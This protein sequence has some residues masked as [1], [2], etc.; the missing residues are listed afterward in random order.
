MKVIPVQSSHQVLINKYVEMLFKQESSKAVQLLESNVNEIASPYLE[1]MIRLASFHPGGSSLYYQR[2]YNIW[3]N[4]NHPPLKPNP[5]NRKIFLLTDFTADH[6]PSL[7]SLFGA[8]YGIDLEIELSPFDSVEQLALSSSSSITKDHI[9]VLIISPQWLQRYLGTSA[10]VSR[11]EFDKTK[12][13]IAS[14]IEG[15]QSQNP[16]QILVANFPG[17]PFPLPGGNLL[18]EEF[19]GQSTAIAEI[20]L[21]LRSIAC[22]NVHLMDFSEAIFGAGG[23]K[24]MAQTNYFRA[25]MVFEPGGVIAASREIALAVATVC[26]KSHRAVVVDWDNTLW[27]GEVAELGYQDVVCGPDSPEGR[28]FQAVQHYI[29]SLTSLGVLLGG[30]SRNS[31]EV[32][33]IFDENSKMGLELDDF[34]STQVSF[35]P[36]SVAIESISEDLGFGEEYMVFLDDSLFELT[37]VF[38]RHPHIDLLMAGPGPDATLHN[39]IESRLF[40]TVS[41]LQDD[42]DRFENSKIL[43]KQR[44]LKTSFK[45]I[46]EFLETIGICLTFCRLNEKN[47]ARAIQLL[48]KSNQFNLTTQRHGKSDL[49]K[50][51]KDGGEINVVS[52]EDAFGS[53]GIISVVILVPNEKEVNIESWVMSC[54]VLNRTVEQAIFSY[55]SES[56]A[57]KTVCGKY[58]PTEKNGLVKNLYSNLGFNF[59]SKDESNGGESWVCPIR[60]K[61]TSLPKHFAKIQEI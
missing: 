35:N 36:K 55:I 24:A 10:L 43:K 41:I 52:Y 58:I 38:T 11:K 26:G 20:N 50:L 49:E 8:S 28:G 19:L 42:L 54:R 22:S 33:S 25:G 3:K 21:W 5:V 40:H 48:Q 32:K 39:L 2:I 56:F 17:G 30:V 34:S 4:L 27:G 15:I 59:V 12:E 44:E 53:Q 18:L 6:F 29:K 1:G 23:R 13:L 47:E 16:L 51:I 9:V 37:E 57:G 31:P 14:I 61:M 7:V 46:D 60:G 45:N